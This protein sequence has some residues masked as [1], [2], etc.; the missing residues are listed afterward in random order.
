MG[1]KYHGGRSD[2]SEPALNEEALPG[3]VNHHGDK[4]ALPDGSQA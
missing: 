4:G 3:C 2:P 1:E